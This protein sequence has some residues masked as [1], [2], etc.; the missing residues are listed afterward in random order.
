M[1]REYA[2]FELRALILDWLVRRGRWGAHHPL[3]TL[4]N[5][6]S[7]ALKNNGKK[8]RRIVKELLEEGY[9]LAHKKGETISLNPTRSRDV[10]EYIRRVM[11]V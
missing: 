6:L 3:D 5:R 11:K 1:K 7:Q 9:I 2:E 4:V 10:A 8:V